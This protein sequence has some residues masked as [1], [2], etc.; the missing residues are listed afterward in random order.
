[1]MAVQ[2]SGAIDTASDD[3]ANRRWLGHVRPPDWPSAAA[4]ATYDLVVLGGGTA[5]LVCAMGAAGLGARV[6]LVERHLLGGDCL[7]TGCVPSK[8]L[9][10]SARIVG[11][12]ARAAALGITPGAAS[13]DFAAVTRR[14]R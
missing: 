10:R 5:G 13:V 2:R 3:A 12:L 11:E 8:A 7:N 4:D 6:A 14:M 9:L 1:M